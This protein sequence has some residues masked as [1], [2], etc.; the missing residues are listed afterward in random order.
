MTEEH[1]F[2]LCG[3]Y[4]TTDVHIAR[5]CYEFGVKVDEL[6]KDQKWLGKIIKKLF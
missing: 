4:K 1:L 6:T 3:I 2:Q 5:A